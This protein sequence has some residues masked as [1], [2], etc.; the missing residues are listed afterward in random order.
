MNNNMDDYMDDYEKAI[1]RVFC[2]RNPLMENL[3]SIP[4]VKCIMLYTDKI[5]NDIV[6]GKS[7]NMMIYYNDQYNDHEVGKFDMFEKI[8]ISDI[9]DIEIKIAFN[10]TSGKC[11]DKYKSYVD[12]S[13]KIKNLIRSLYGIYVSNVFD[14]TFAIEPLN[15]RS[16]YKKGFIRIVDHEYVELSFKQ[17]ENFIKKFN[18]DNPLLSAISELIIKNCT[19]NAYPQSFTYG[20]TNIRTDNDRIYFDSQDYRHNRDYRGSQIYDHAGQQKVFDELTSLFTNIIN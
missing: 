15:I 12:K 2:E 8:D 16:N 10:T 20:S 17:T 4:D 11:Y 18:E 14:F 1:Y 5:K 9:E 6:V 3:I 13:I 19:R 7:Y